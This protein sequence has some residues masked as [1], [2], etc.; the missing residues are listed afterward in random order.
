MAEAKNEQSKQ[1]YNVAL[2]AATAAEAAAAAAA[3]A[4]A[5][6]VRLTGAPRCMGK[7]KEEIAAIKI[8]TAFRGYMVMISLLDLI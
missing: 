4:A 2:A 5:E 6:V 1:A 8:Q 7:S 3:H